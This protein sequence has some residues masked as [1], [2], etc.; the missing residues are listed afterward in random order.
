M[1]C[2][3]EHMHTFAVEIRLIASTAAIVAVS[4]LFLFSVGATAGGVCHEDIAVVV[5]FTTVATVVVTV[6]TVIVA[7]EVAVVIVVVVVVTVVATVLVFGAPIATA[8]CI[9]VLGNFVPLV[10]L[11]SEENF[12]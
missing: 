11:K 3:E 6:S 9:G 8:I 5:I 10:L 2:E 1:V 4:E 12:S 7:V